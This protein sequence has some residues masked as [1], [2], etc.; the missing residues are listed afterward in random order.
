VIGGFPFWLVLIISGLAICIATIIDIKKRE[1]PDT[2]TFSLIF[3]GLILGI[4]SSVFSLSFIPLVS[5][6]AGLIFGYIV[7]SALFYT[8][9]WGG[10]DAKMLMGLGA[11]WGLPIITLIREGFLVNEI[12]ALLLLF[13]GIF[14]AGL[15]YGLVVVFIKI[16]CKFKTFSKAFYTISHQEPYNYVRWIIF[17]VGALCILGGLFFKV[18][19]IQLLFAFLAL[20]FILGYYL[21]LSV[22][23]VEKK[24]FIKEVP[25][26]TIT[27]GEW[28]AKE[29][30]ISSK[31]ESGVFR[32]KEFWEMMYRGKE[33]HKDKSKNAFVNNQTKKTIRLLIYETYA[34]TFPVVSLFKQVYVM[35]NN[36][37]YERLRKKVVYAL[38]LREEKSSLEYCKKNNILYLPKSLEKNNIYFS[39]QVIAI[40]QPEG[41]SLMQIS[42]LKKNKITTITIKEGIA[43]M[44]AFLLGFVVYVVLFILQIL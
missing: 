9:Q 35:M 43:F 19:E 11:L 32:I 1:V 17:S 44:P 28:V 7:G 12:P 16:I 36:S 15:V 27:E 4:V 23:V 2:L 3:L 13:I 37:L 34:G 20:C 6:I 14:L 18:I 33:F 29:I 39:K 41:L 8:G 24:L 31:E 26:E 5:S 38:H 42:A 22:K 21:F 40:P 25:I 10:G 30:S